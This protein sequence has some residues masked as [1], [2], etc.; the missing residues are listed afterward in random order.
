MGWDPDGM[1]SDVVPVKEEVF[2]CQSSVWRLPDDVYLGHA[3]KLCQTCLEQV[4]E[5]VLVLKRSSASPSPSISN[6]GASGQLPTDSKATLGRCPW[7]LPVPKT[8]C[9]RRSLQ[10]R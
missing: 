10:T 2:V 5:R 7:F 1:H 6:I 8:A 9:H 3:G 4:A